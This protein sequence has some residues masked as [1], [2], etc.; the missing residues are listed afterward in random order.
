MIRGGIMLYKYFRKINIAFLMALI[1]CL[2][3]ITGAV[4]GNEL[5]VHDI[6]EIVFAED[7][8][9]VFDDDSLL[10]DEI[11]NKN[12]NEINST[13][14]VSWHANG[15]T[16]IPTSW[17]RV[18]GSFMGVLP[19]PSRTGFQFV[20]WFNT[21]S[22]TGGTQITS[23]SLFPKSNTTY[24]ARWVQLFTVTLNPMG[25]TVNPNS[26]SIPQGSPIG[27]I[28]NPTRSGYNFAGW[29]TT[30]T[31]GVLVTSSLAITSNRTI[32]ARW[33][34]TITLNANGGSIN[35]STIQR[36]SGSTMG[37]LPVPK[38][39]STRYGF[40]F[41]G[42]VTAI[43]GGS[44]VTQNTI[45]QN[46][47]T[48]IIARWDLSINPTRHLGYWWPSTT[49][50]LG[51]FQVASGVGLVHS[52]WI[53]NM[54]NGRNSWNNSSAPVTFNNNYSVNTVVA[55]PSTSD[56]LGWVNLRRTNTTIDDFNITLNTTAI[57][58][59][60]TVR[61]YNVNNAAASVMAHELGHVLGLRDGD[62]FN[63]GGSANA[64]VMNYDANRNIITGP[65]AY[66]IESVKLIY[67]E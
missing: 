32:F 22:N 64:S 27:S 36:T 16:V 49:I 28:P 53:N 30:E 61:N 12:I 18:P 46:T 3:P 54:N 58:D 59:Y 4:A 13:V 39:T 20:G 37:T 48:T 60:A 14:T 56:Y 67:D 24:Y 65:T 19:T 34:I 41:L 26:L 25:G 50:P 62:T 52:T 38:R 2:L 43:P 9:Y 42:W 10:D 7:E 15:G 8:E 5:P 63:L 33:T 29:Y 11:I 40:A 17:T 55:A 47:N 21:S 44:Q 6:N 35:P 51:T 1:L 31:G 57:I 66:D 45:V 23:T